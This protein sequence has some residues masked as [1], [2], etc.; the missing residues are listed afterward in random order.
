MTPTQQ[1]AD[2]ATTDPIYQ[3]QNLLD[4]ITDAW[5][6]APPTVRTRLSLRI[7]KT[8]YRLRSLPHKHHPPFVGRPISTRQPLDV[9]SYVLNPLMSG[10]TILIPEDIPYPSLPGDF[11]CITHQ[12]P[13]YLDGKLHI[14]MD[15]SKPRILVKLQPHERH[16][17]Y[18]KNS[19][20]GIPSLKPTC[21]IIDIAIQSQNQSATRDLHD[22]C[23]WL[24]N[25]GLDLRATCAERLSK[26]L[27]HP[28]RDWIYDP[29]WN[30]NTLTDKQRAYL[31][32][33]AENGNTTDQELADHIGIHRHTVASTRVDFT[34]HHGP[35]HLRRAL[36]AGMLKPPTQTLAPE[37]PD[38]GRPAPQ[39]RTASAGIG[40]GSSP[41][42][43]NPSV[44][45]SAT[46]R[47]VRTDA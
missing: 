20:T 7:D 41:A 47:P 15:T 6:S 1:L 13:D 27:T 44:P 42:R 19:S 16:P 46:D 2:I 23:T 17:F 5:N 4:K 24:I 38:A 33:L 8:L 28:R 26:L 40:D 30:P 37:R 22:T 32:A 10:I 45:P 14:R 11:T 31:T 43:P 18:R 35:D 12:T 9:V 39:K 29:N 34:T 25:Y 36:Q 21:P 3:T